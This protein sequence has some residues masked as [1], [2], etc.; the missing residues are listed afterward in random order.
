MSDIDKKY[1]HVLVVDDN[2]MNRDMLA[3]RLA[4]IGLQVEVADGGDSGL[5]KI[6]TGEFDLVLLDIM[7][8]D[9]DG[10]EVLKRAREFYS[11]AEL[12]IIMATAKDESKDIVEALKLGANDYVTKPLDF[13]VVRAR[14]ENALGYRQ[15]VCEL[16]KAN[17]RMSRD[18]EAAARVQ[19]ALLP[20]EMVD[21]EGAE[22]MWLYRP[23]DE[24]AGDGLNVFKLDDD[25]VAM[26]V[27]DV[28]GHG[29]ASSLLSVSVTHHLSQ[30]AG[31]HGENSQGSMDNADF[32]SPAWLASNL[33]ALFPMEASGRHYFTFLYGVLNVK[34]GKFCFVSAGSPGPMVVHADGTA[35]FHD[36]P[37]VPIGMFSDSEYHDTV[38]DLA[39][40]DRLYLHSD[41]LYEERHPETREEF[42]RDRMMQ[43][44]S[45]AT[46]GSFITSAD[47]LVEAVA[48][49]RGDD[50]FADDITLLACAIRS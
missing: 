37:A 21:I 14:V 26:Y 3:R 43:A 42:G 49:W 47:G 10:I 15:A 30:L 13:P 36:V 9:I 39:D 20:D 44:L 11:Q 22:F 17:E 38:I 16:S 35:E 5:E 34:T 8:P 4:R 25:H 48:K 1:S 33:N 45:A 29:V 31:K 23:C 6:L 19:Q 27:L 12:P 18:L 41:G 50:E 46:A 7:M 28:S 40:G 24:L 32:V 2:E